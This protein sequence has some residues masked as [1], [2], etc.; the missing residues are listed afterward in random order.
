M[1]EFRNYQKVTRKQLEEYKQF[2]TPKQDDPSLT[3]AIQLGIGEIEG[4]VELIER[5][6]ASVVEAL[7]AL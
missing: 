2:F 1:K 5:D 3:R 4:R 6:Q 7:N